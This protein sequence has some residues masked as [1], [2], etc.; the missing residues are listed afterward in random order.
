MAFVG[1]LAGAVLTATPALAAPSKVTWPGPVK[2]SA[3]RGTENHIQ[4]TYVLVAGS[5]SH[6]INDRA[7]VTTVVTEPPSCYPEGSQA[8]SC[9]D[10]A[11]GD[12]GTK[13]PGESF[14]VVLGD[15]DD[16]FWALSVGEFQV[17]AG[18]GD[19][20]VVGNDDPA[21]QPAMED[22]PEVTFYSEDALYGDAGDDFL[23]G[24]KGPDFL[25]GGSGNDVLDAGEQAATTTSTAQPTTLCSGDRGTTSSTR[26]TATATW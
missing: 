16:R 8:V 17:R 3:A 4:I 22:E 21:V 24:R 1:A 7:G 15:R 9:P 6:F 23:S 2:V 14:S 18:D 25:Y 20:Y 19:D 13:G 10:G 11:S 5:W 26:P 12:D